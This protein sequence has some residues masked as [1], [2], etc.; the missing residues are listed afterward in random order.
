MKKNYLTI[1][2][3]MFITLFSTM[4]IK[5]Q[6]IGDVFTVDDLIYEITDLASSGAANTVLVSN[7]NR[8]NTAAPYNVPYP[9]ATLTIPATVDYTDGATLTYTVTN[10]TSDAFRGNTNIV[11]LVINATTLSDSFRT[12]RDATNITTVSIPNL[13]SGFFG[14][15]N[16]QGCT[17]LES[18]SAPNWTGVFNNSVFQDCSAL[19]TV[20]LPGLTGVNNNT[21]LRCSSL[22]TISLPAL[23]TAGN[24]TFKNCK[25]L[26]N[27]SLPVL[28]TTG[29]QTFA[30]D[31]VANAN[32]IVSLDLPLLTNIG[33]LNFWN[34]TSL[35]TLNVPVVETIAAN[36]FNGTGLEVVSFPA[37]LTA[38]D[39]NNTFHNASGLKYIAFANA[40]V[41]D[42]D[43]AMFGTAETSIASNPTLVVP[44]GASAAFETA[45]DYAIF[46]I[47]EGTLSKTTTDVTYSRTLATENWFL[48]SSPVNDERYDGTYVTA[49]SIDATGTLAANRGIATYTTNGN[50]WSY[51]QV[52]EDLPFTPG[53]GY[54]VKREDAA[55]AGEISFTGTSLNS[56]NIDNI[57]V[58]TDTDG[59]NLLGN[60]FLANIN[61][62][63]FLTANA[64]LSGEIWLFNQSNGNYE[65]HV[66]GDNKVLT[67]GQGF[68]VKANSGS[69]VDF[70]TTIQTNSTTGTFQK[71]AI[72]KI[73][74]LIN[75]GDTE[76]FA[77][78]YFTES[79]T[80]GFD[81]GWD[82]ATFTGVANN[83]DVFTQ[84]LKDNTGK[85]YQV[86]S[87]SNESIE[88][89]VVPVGLIS[90]AGKQ[91]TF[92]AESLNLPENVKVYLE[93][94][95]SNTFTKLDENATYKVSLTEAVNGIGRFYLHTTTQS[96]LSTS[97]A[98]LEN[99]SIYKSNATT[100]KIVGLSQGKT[101]VK[102]FNILGNQVINTS[103]NSN[104]VK[105]ISLQKLATGIYIVQLE[106]EAGK[107]SKKIIL[108]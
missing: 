99:V 35:K 67:S 9:N 85:N 86:Q 70:A 58:S 66:T 1:T 5:A 45:T 30:G 108:E 51:M 76:R 54:S 105:E 11:T 107:L 44:N 12:F 64:N 17:K 50:S 4:L 96:V 33:G 15:L 3:V 55:G 92:S 83:F 37:T 61:S 82:G 75:S 38:I 7:K 18:I 41:L 26:T 73:K 101:N 72:S 90:E 34:T 57:P 8:G 21:F 19:T 53:V 43:P 69:V 42:I 95:S 28:T 22:V 2:M 81:K 31:V 10:I 60:P 40:T 27:V 97:D 106:T 100:L 80:A 59:Y 84:L 68:F 56:G 78:I 62:G 32:Q 98:I 63:A 65:N 71:T 103:F 16:F 36:A 46:S 94:R 89:S 29:A 93:D 14:A 48:V 79:A 47:V 52:G 13:T 104:G 74:L 77:K 25:L 87:L 39:G 23:T 88:T 49:N 91:I 6:T 20:T 102:L 24:Q